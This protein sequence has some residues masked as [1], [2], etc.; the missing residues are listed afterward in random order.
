MLYLREVDLPGCLL[1][2]GEIDSPGCYNSGRL[3]RQ[4]VIP[5]GDGLAGM[6]YLREI[7][8]PMGV[9]PLRDLLAGI[10]YLWE[11]DSPKCYTPRRYGKIWIT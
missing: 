11:N 6:L 2:L 4:G 8:S 9:I 10:I 3:T 7:D 1:Y 5:Q